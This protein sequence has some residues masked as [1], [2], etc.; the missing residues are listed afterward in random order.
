M[1]LVHVIGFLGAPAFLLQAA[2]ADTKL[3]G[4][5]A[6]PRDRGI[7]FVLYTVHNNILKLAA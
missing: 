2:T 3:L 7:C 4:V 5:H 6:V 1:R